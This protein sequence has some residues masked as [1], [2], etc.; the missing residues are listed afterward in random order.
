MER[1]VSKP[2]GLLIV[3]LPYEREGRA[4]V[5]AS[6]TELLVMAPCGGLVVLV[7]AIFVNSLLSGQGHTHWWFPSGF[8]EQR[9]NLYYLQYIIYL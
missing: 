7:E 9:E 4:V 6:A 3:R 5:G 8:E 2:C 1:G